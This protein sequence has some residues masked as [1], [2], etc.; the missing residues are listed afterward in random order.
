MAISLHAAGMNIRNIRFHLAETI[1]I[2]LCTK[3]ISDITEQI[4]NEVLQWH[5]RPLD[6]VSSVIFMYPIVVK[7]CELDRVQKR[8]SHIADG[9]TDGT[10]HALG[11]WIQLH[12]GAK[13]GHESAQN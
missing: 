6:A 8:A 7:I 11:T 13:S 3:T 10:P 4:M 5:H 12:E 2:E 1:G 9:D